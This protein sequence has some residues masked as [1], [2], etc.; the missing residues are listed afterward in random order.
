MLTSTEVLAK[1]AAY[2]GS[3]E[4]EEAIPIVGWAMKAVLIQAGVEQLAQTIAEVAGSTRVTEF[5][6]TV[7][8][9]VEFNLVPA[10]ASG[11]ANTATTYTVTAQYTDV[12]GYVWHGDVPDDKTAQITFTWDKMPVGGSVRF[13]VALYSVEGWLV[14]SGTTDTLDNVITSG[15]TAL[16]VPPIRVQQT[17]YPLTGATSYVHQRVLGFENDEH[18]W[19]YTSQAPAVTARNLGV[20]PGDHQLEA[21]TSISLN[22]DLGIL[23]YGWQAT[24]QGVPAIGTT[25]P[26]Q[27][28]YTFQNIAFGS[29]DR[30]QVRPNNGLMF[31]PAGYTTSPLLAYV[32]SG[33][34]SGDGGEE[35]ARRFAFLDP[36]FA[37]GYHMR[38]ISPIND[39]TIPVD[40]A[41]RSFDLGT[42]QNW[43]ASH[44]GPHQWPCTAGA[45]SWGWRLSTRG[46]RS[47]TSAP[48]PGRDSA[49]W[50]TLVSGPARVPDSWGAQR[51]W[52]SRPTKPCWCWKPATVGSR[53][54]VAPAIRV[55]PSPAHRRSIGSRCTS[56]RESPPRS[57]TSQCPWRSKATSTFCPTRTRA[58]TLVTSV[59]TSI[60]PVGCT[61]S[62]SAGWRS[63][64]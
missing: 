33:A 62:A 10:D 45:T 38:S 64:R 50:A 14:G 15:R 4:A 21:L 41:Q 58:M 44:C 36:D 53:R 23:G 57:R 1:L 61:C 24:S 48:S 49:P 52:R 9:P 6:L 63:P 37:N 60:R 26:S 29:P 46:C 7:T 32:R 47:S 43:V 55:R 39:P 17:L 27:P 16:V 56:S 8:M 59:W 11:F 42:D 51:W 20:G 28:V 25:D 35:S 12:T 40:N 13:L 31:T 34:E 19:T 5:G 54:S 22:S 18:T 3:E 2:F 30:V